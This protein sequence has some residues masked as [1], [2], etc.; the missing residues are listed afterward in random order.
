MSQSDLFMISSLLY[1]KINRLYSKY[2]KESQKS[3]KISFYFSGVNT[4]EEY[5]MVIKIGKAIKKDIFM[6]TSNMD[7]FLEIP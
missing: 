7:N 5:K 2:Y 4:K 3:P 6:L 1:Y